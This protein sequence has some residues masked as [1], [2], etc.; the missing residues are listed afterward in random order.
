MGKTDKL[1][2]LT[3]VIIIALINYFE[4]VT[5]PWNYVLLGIA[6]IFLVTSFLNFCPLYPIFGMNTFNV[7]DKDPE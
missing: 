6:I 4:I 3:I 5:E 2:R 7:T 1:L